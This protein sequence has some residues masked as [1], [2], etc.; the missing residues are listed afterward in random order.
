M[1]FLDSPEEFDLDSPTDLVRLSVLSKKWFA[2]TASF[3]ILNF[4][5][6]KFETSSLFPYDH[7]FLK[8]ADY[9]TS[10]FCKQNVSAHTFNLIAL[11]EDPSQ[12][13]IIDK[14]VRSILKKGVKVLLLD[15]IDKNF[16]LVYL[17]PD[18]LL[19]AT[20]LT[21]LT[22]F[23]CDLPSSLTVDDVKFKSLKLLDLDYVLLDEEMIECLTSNCPL[24]EEM[25]LNR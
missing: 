16:S 9:T 2:L 3:P 23:N 1:S 20:L 11:I 22:L 15:I 24:L 17:L 6:G 4:D 21:S 5:I 8:Y 12:L 18:L 25:H 13:S 19:S 10:R 7:L 14:C